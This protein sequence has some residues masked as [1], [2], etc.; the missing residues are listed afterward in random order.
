AAVYGRL[1]VRLPVAASEVAYTGA[2][3]PRPVSF[4]AGWAMTFAYLIVCPYEAVAA[5]RIAAHL[6]P[7]LKP[8]ELYTVAGYP[9]YLPT[10]ALGLALTAGITLLNYRGVYFSA[11]F[12]NL[13]T[14]G[15]LAA[16]AVFAPLGFWRGS[17]ANLPPLFAAGSS[18]TGALLSVL[19]VL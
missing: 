18:L 6:F 12:Q 19:A 7:E 11:T 15:L 14:F 17:V 2:V 16:F 10:L 3:F 8:F 1:A 9:V 13:T 5:G 4:A